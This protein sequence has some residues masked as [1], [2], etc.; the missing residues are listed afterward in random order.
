MAENTITPNKTTGNFIK[1]PC[2]RCDLKTNHEV[3]SSVQTSWN[4]DWVYMDTDFEIVRCRGCDSISFRSAYTC[5]EDMATD[6]ET[7]ETIYFVTEELYPNRIAGKKAIKE[8]HFLPHNI[9]QIY[10]E[11]HDAMCR[12]ARILASTGIRILVEAIC[13]LEGAQGISLEKK[14]DDLVQKGILTPDNAETLH[15]A[16]LLGNKSAHEGEQSTEMEVGIAMDIVEN[17]MHRVYIIPKKA[18]KLPRRK[19]SI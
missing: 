11:V 16:R 18:S 1:I 13:K 19:T 15:S 4:D 8:S 7:G 2:F 17:L 10:T 14:I 9:S 12:N 6:E 3:M 5:S